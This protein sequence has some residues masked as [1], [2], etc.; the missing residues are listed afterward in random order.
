MAHYLD[1]GM[2]TLTEDEC[3]ALLA[4]TEVGRLAVCVG[5]GPEIFPVNF[6][7]DNRTLVFRTAEGAKLTAVAIAPQVA[8]EADGFS[9]A[10]GEA[11]SVVVRGGARVLERLNDVYAVQELPLFPWHDAP[12][13]IFVRVEPTKVSGRRF[14]A[15]RHLHEP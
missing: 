8:F 6:V 14:V 7:I 1:P 4:Q 13:A 11:W 3:W 2:V 9:T 12:K 10:R 5:D 15:A